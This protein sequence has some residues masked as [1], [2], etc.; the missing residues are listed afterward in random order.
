MTYGGECGFAETELALSRTVHAFTHNS[1]RKR[2]ETCN[3]KEVQGTLGDVSGD[4]L[5]FCDS[6]ARDSKV[7]RFLQQGETLCFFLGIANV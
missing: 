4:A 1:Q 3:G 2:R 7:C 5:L 6:Y